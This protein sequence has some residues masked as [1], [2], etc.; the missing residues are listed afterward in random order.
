M[1]DW[2]FAD[3][4]E[5]VAR[6]APEAPCHIQGARTVSWGDFDRRAN[7]LAADLLDAGLQHQ[8]KV[9]AYLYNGPE[10]LETYFAAFKAGMA[11]VNTNYRYGPEE[12]LYLFDNADAEAIVFHSSFADL[13]DKVRDRLPKVKRWYAVDDGGGIPNWA[14]SY[15][16]VVA[17]G[18]A[19][20]VRGPW[21]RSGEDLLLLYTGGTT[22][23]PKG[24]M[25]RQ[26]DLFN[27]L[28]AG[29][30][31]LV[32]IPRA[33][34]LEELASRIDPER[35]GLVMLPACPLMHGTGQFSSFITMGMGGTIVTLPSRRFSPDELWR[36]A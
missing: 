35:P 32:G 24:V 28:G 4:F 11:P 27:V 15:E 1:S 21:G 6:R 19:E 26:D 2:N 25:W 12:I 36:E 5:A 30:N 31:G 10:Y 33:T 17:Q 3:A 29:G 7:G 20:P 16:E 13:I 22:G 9:A 8:A 23:M 34:S 18:T 14:T